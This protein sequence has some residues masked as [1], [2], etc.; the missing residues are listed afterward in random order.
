[1]TAPS[2]ESS[3]GRRFPFAR[4][5][6]DVTIWPKA[7]ILSP[8][9]IEIGDSVIIDDFVML[10]GGERTSIGSFVHIAAYASV[11]GGGVLEMADFSALSGGVRLYTGTDDFSGEALAGPTVPDRFRKVERSRVAL[12]RHALVGTGCVVLPGVRIGEG[13]AVG[14]N[15]LV[16]RDLAPWTIYAGSPARPLRPRN[17]ERMLALEAELRR[18]L[19]D[20]QGRY[21]PKRMREA[22]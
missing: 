20:A 14:A 21:I 10:M 6:E 1:M 17:R 8:E 9:R 2:E 13:A 4:I 19:Y 18:E 3:D 7:R 12:G 16:N 11:M 22:G 5:G 15:S